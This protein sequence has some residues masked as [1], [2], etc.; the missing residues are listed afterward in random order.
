METRI[1][2]SMAGWDRP[3][4]EFGARF[5]LGT[6]GRTELARW[7][8]LV[9]GRRAGRQFRAAL[10][11]EAGRTVACP[12][13]LTPSTLIEAFFRETGSLSRAP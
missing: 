5:L 12:R 10:T 8:V 1:T 4:P 13:I 11:R 6:E 2:V 9:P 7:G 3:P